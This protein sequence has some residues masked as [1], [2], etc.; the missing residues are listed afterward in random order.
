MN[1]LIIVTERIFVFLWITNYLL[2][3]IVTFLILYI[4]V[5]EKS[6]FFAFTSLFLFATLTSYH[7]LKVYKRVICKKIKKE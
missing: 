6:Y 3:S 5:N 2:W 1:K 4:S 7:V